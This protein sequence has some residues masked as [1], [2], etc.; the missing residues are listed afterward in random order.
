MSI[1]IAKAIVQKSISFLPYKHRI[2]Y[3]FQKYITKGVSFTDDYFYDRLIRAKNHI[4]GYNRHSSKMIPECTLEIG[5]GWYPTVPISMYLMGSLKIYSVDISMLTSL[6]RIKITIEK[7]IVANDN[8]TLKEYIN[9]DDKRMCSLIHLYKMYDNYTLS[10]VLE[11]LNIIYLI[12]DARKM[13]LESDTIDLITSNN[14]FEHI[15][16][17]KL[18]PILIE[19]ERVLKKGGVSSHFIDLC[20]HFSYLDKEI[21]IYNFLKFSDFQ[22]QIIDNNIQPQNRARY[23]DY[24]KL[25]QEIRVNVVEKVLNKGNHSL[26]ANTPLNK[27]YLQHSMDELAICEC[28]IYTKK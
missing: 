14:T 3:F 20:D 15:Y 18:L 22:W 23:F 8:G 27:K 26:L 6:E 11:Y 16:L 4:D 25:F 12:G 21:T 24:Q 2:N 17:D 13:N 5:T 1:W 28:H 19:F 7:F 9:F 10:Q